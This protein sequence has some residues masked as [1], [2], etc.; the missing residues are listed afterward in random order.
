MSVKYLKSIFEDGIVYFKISRIKDASSEYL[1]DG[2]EVM[3]QEEEKNLWEIDEYELTETDLEEMYEDGF[4]DIDEL[5]FTEAYAKASK[6]L[7]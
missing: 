6:F 1:Y 4:C 7:S 5:E 2:L 3:Y